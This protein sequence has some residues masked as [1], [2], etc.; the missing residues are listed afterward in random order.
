MKGFIAVV[1]QAR[2]RRLFYLLILAGI[3][4]IK[5]R[6]AGFERWT[7]EFFALDTG[8]P[9]IEERIFR[10]SASREFDIRRYVEE[11]LLGPVS[12]ESAPLFSR[13]S[14]L[15]ALMIRDGTVYANL[16]EIAA[17]PPPEG[18]EPLVSLASLRRGIRRNFSFVKDVRLYIEGNEVA[19]AKL[20]AASGG[21]GETA[22]F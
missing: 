11:T 4:F 17:L 20:R 1:R 18:G 21:K 16:S 22:N 5:V 2:N 14:R 15:L 9:R 10:R 13:D 19:P 6:G 7:F 3:A 12:P 8:K